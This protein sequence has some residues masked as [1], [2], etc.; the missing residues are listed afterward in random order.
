MPEGAAGKETLNRGGQVSGCLSRMG[1]GTM[2]RSL[3]LKVR[4]RG[5]QYT[6]TSEYR[7]TGIK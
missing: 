5:C 1:T 3:E 6:Q 7:H 4:T 2:K